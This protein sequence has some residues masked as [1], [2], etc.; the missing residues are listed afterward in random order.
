MTMPKTCAVYGCRGNYRGQPYVPVVRFP[1]D[2]V[3]R[4]RWIKSMP[5]A[6]NSLV[7]RKDLFICASHFDCEWVVSRGGK[8]P[9]DPPSVFPGVP[10]SCLKQSKVKKRSTSRTSST[11]RELR[12]KERQ[13][14]DNN[15]KDF[16]SFLQQL[17]RRYP[18]YSLKV[19]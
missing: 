15:M 16:A 14:Q 8:R 13:M 11:T 19:D 12:E 10:K 2:E 6:G 4:D 1:T 7:N 18:L 5:N 3:E 9:V 17:P